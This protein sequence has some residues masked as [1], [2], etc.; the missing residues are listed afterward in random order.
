MRILLILLLLVLGLLQC[1]AQGNFTSFFEPEIEINYTVSQKYSQSFGIENRNVIYKDL[2]VGYVVKQIDVSHFL[3]FKLKEN[4]TIGF[5]VQYRFENTFDGSEENEFRFMQQFQWENVNSGYAIISR[6]RNEQ[7][8]YAS[9]IKFRLRYKL[10]LKYFL[11]DTTNTYIKTEAEALLELAQI[12]K[13]EMEQRIS[14]FY[15]FPVF[16][17]TDFEIGAQY[18]LVD[19]TQDLGHELFIVMGFGLHLN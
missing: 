11:K 1:K 4:Q 15:G 14:A 10:G 13:P 12:Q 7:R 2:N 9:N 8:I 17:N 3:A 6:I 16:P 19:Y 18:R 5:G